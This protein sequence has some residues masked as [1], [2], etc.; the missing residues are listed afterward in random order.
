MWGKFIELEEY[1]MQSVRTKIQIKDITE[2]DYHVVKSWEDY[3]NKRGKIVKL[4]KNP[5]FGQN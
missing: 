1:S 3:M 2:K 5:Y 4:R